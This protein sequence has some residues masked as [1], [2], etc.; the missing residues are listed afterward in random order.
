MLE[1]GD[2]H[3]VGNEMQTCGEIVGKLKNRDIP[4]FLRI[5]NNN[6]RCEKCKYRYIKIIYI[7]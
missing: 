7:S 2:K 5:G 6:I 3:M 4:I 1:E